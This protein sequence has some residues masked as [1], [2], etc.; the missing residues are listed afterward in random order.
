MM[1]SIFIGAALFVTYCSV[2]LSASEHDLKPS[3]LVMLP[4]GEVKA[5]VSGDLAS[6]KN[7]EN[8][9]KQQDQVKP[10]LSKKEM[11]DMMDKLESDVILLLEQSKL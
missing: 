6:S 10:S 2:A 1:R 3:K 7:V 8:K 11:D 4:N 9:L 5:L